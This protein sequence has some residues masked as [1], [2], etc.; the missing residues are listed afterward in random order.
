MEKDILEILEFNEIRKKLAELAPSALSKK[1]AL[2]LLPSSVPEV[3]EKSLQ[4][5][6]EASVLLEREITTP[7]EKPMTFWKH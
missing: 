2:E 4:E 7:W 6:E 1:M 5:T 3:V